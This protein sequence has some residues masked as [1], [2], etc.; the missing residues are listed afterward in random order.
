MKNKILSITRNW[1][2]NMG[3]F[4]LLAI[5]IINS[6]A[7]FAQRTEKP[8]LGSR[9]CGNIIRYVDLTGN[10]TRVGVVINCREY[11][12]YINRNDPAN[13]AYTDTYNKG[14]KSH[15]DRNGR[16]W[17]RVNVGMVLIAY[18]D[19]QKITLPIK[20]LRYNGY[21][22]ELGVK[23]S[24]EGKN[25]GVFELVFDRLPSGIKYFSILDNDTRDG[26]WWEEIEIKNPKLQSPHKNLSES[27]I[28]KIIINN[29]DGICGI[30]ENSKYKLACI[31]ENGKYSVVYISGGSSKF[32]TWKLGDVKAEMRE[33]AVN[34]MFKATWYDSDKS[35]NENGYIAFDGATMKVSID[36]DEATFLKM[37]PSASDVSSSAEETA[38]AW[39]GSGI[40]IGSK[41]IATNNHVVEGAKTLVVCGVKG[42]MNTTYKVQVVATDKKNDLAIVK[43]VDEKFKGFGAIPY[44]FNYSTVD[45]GTE[46]F[47]LGYPMT[48]V[49]GNEIKLTNGIINSKSGF[50]GDIS[51]YQMSATIQHGNSGGPVFDNKGNLIGISVAGIK[52]EVAQNVNYA[53]KLSYLRTLIESCN[54]KIVVPKQNTIANSSLVNKVKAIK[55]F[56]LML[57]ANV[58]DIE[59][60][61]RN[62]ETST[63]HTKPN[64]SSEY[65]NA[66]RRKYDWVGSISDGLIV[67]KK[68][69]KYG[70]VDENFNIVIP[71]Q[72]E[73]AFSFING[74]AD[75]SINGKWIKIDKTGKPLPNQSFSTSQTTTTSNNIQVGRATKTKAKTLK[76][77]DVRV[78]YKKSDVDGLEYVTT[79]KETSGWGGLVTEKGTKRCIKALQKKAAK[80]G[81]IA[82]LITDYPRQEVFAAY[83]VAEFYKQP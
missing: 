1:L 61:Q 54:E 83:A 66:A 76:P 16:G 47:V 53:V 46:I 40:V 25:G 55:P 41:Y 57:Q 20:A 51:T 21:N 73:E 18:L 56:V 60:R 22:Q 13:V 63:A 36:G 26:L 10:E 58:S 71:L 64:I 12:D 67:V 29:N 34:G 74:V 50:Q 62:V 82:I 4:I 77:E 7:L 38:Q 37:F 48:Q 65:E 24:T 52:S 32:S 5:A 8:N 42:N 3:R 72:Y 75:V 49:M 27:D 70:Y 17:V 59:E 39:S 30:Y 44:S 23:L 28:K 19:G 11:I 31:K 45:V 81:C 33:S 35:K 9:H 43:V 6:C 69:G 80:L 68:A 78:F 14:V 2:L 79:E 15:N